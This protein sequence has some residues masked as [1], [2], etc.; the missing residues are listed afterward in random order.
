MLVAGGETYFNLADTSAKRSA[1]VKL[2]ESGRDFVVRNYQVVNRVDTVTVEYQGRSLSL[3]LVAA[4][5]GKAAPVSMV[6]PGPVPVPGQPQ[7]TA[8]LNPTPADESRR[9]E[10]FRAEIARRRAQRAQQA[11]PQAGQPQPQ[12]QTR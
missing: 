9:L 7:P 2:N 3:S 4:K 8:V 12:Q 1:W 11:Q 6:A 5:T 10:E